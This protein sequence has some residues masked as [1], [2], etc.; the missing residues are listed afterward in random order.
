M[1]TS[2]YLEIVLILMQD[3]CMVCHERTQALKSFWMHPM[4][5]LG[6]VGLVKSCFGSFGN[7]VS[8]GAR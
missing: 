8:V 6:A 4:E 1:L 3:R 5:L 7:S 2:V